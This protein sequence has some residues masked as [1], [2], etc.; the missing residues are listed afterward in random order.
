MVTVTFTGVVFP[1]GVSGTGHVGDDETVNVWGNMV[2]STTTTWT[3]I[4]A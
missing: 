4:A 1:T 3:E 2:P